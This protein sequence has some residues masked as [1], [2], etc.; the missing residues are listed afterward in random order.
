MPRAERHSN[1]RLRTAQSGSARRTY[2]VV[3][4]ASRAALDRLARHCPVRLGSP[5]LQRRRCREPS[6]TIWSMAMLRNPETISFWHGRLPHWEVVGGRY[7]V[8]IHLA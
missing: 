4:A 2:S 7:F 1:V 3:D 6:G 8:T 5:D